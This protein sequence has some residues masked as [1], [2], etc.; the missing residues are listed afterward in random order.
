MVM[1]LGPNLKNAPFLNWIGNLNPDRGFSG[2]VRSVWWV[3]VTCGWIEWVRGMY[4]S[5]FKPETNLFL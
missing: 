3:K 4:G 2:C 5:R 1:G